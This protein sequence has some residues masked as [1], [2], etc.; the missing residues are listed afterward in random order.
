MSQSVQAPRVLN[1][2]D[3]RRA[4][5]RRLPRVVC[6]Y[7]DGGAEDEW[8]LGANSRAFEAVTLRPRCAVA[9]PSCSLRTALVGASLPM[10]LILAPVRSSR[11]VPPR[12]EE[13]A[14]HAA[15]A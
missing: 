10:R 6:E 2:E 12:G 9:V 3:L 15:A 1:I 5:K 4:A 11:L 7:I 14:S 13:A 8:T